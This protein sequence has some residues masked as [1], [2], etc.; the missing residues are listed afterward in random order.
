MWSWEFNIFFPISTGFQPSRASSEQIC[1]VLRFFCDFPLH[2]AV[3][4]VKLAK[5]LSV[6]RRLA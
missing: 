1:V 6:C 5:Y 2:I 4:L 3:K